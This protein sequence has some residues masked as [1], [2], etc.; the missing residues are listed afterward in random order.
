MKKNRL[1]VV[2]CVRV[3]VVL[4]QLRPHCIIVRCFQVDPEKGISLRFPRF[5]RIREDKKP[6]EA[7]SSQQVRTKTRREVPLCNV[8]I[9]SDWKCC[10]QSVNVSQSRSTLR[11]CWTPFQWCRRCDLVGVLRILVTT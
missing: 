6:E 2:V 1:C 9:L 3:C 8:I 4:F 10:S 5:V 11:G 7:T